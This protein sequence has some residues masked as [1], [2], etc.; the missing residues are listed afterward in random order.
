ME[1]AGS[2]VTWL[3]GRV[4]ILERAELKSDEETEAC[5]VRAEDG[6]VEVVV[7][8]C[9]HSLCSGYG[10]T[11]VRLCVVTRSA[12]T[13]IWTFDSRLGLSIAVLEGGQGP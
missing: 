2:G 4:G 5:S 13:L 8:C 6:E 10:S 3:G 12:I 1:S 9:V 7:A 11:M